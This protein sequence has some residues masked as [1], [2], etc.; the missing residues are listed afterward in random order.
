MGKQPLAA[1]T[2]VTKRPGEARNI[3]AKGKHKA[4]ES[5]EEDTKEE[6]GSESEPS[7]SD[8]SPDKAPPPAKKSRGRPQKA[9]IKDAACQLKY[10]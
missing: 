10:M 8:H 4:K 6:T 3:K 2:S 9:I 1:S 5:R 7:E